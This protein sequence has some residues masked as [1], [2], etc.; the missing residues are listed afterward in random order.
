MKRTDITGQMFGRLMVTSYSHTKKNRAFWNCRCLC[1]TLRVVRGLDIRGGSTKSC[2]CL[3]R[4]KTAK[5]STTH[6]HA[7]GGKMSPT[8]YSWMSMK[9]RCLSKRHHIYKSYGGRG[10]T[11]CK[12]WLDFR[13][14]LSDMGERPKGM[15]IDRKNNNRGYSPGNCRWATAQQQARNRSDTR[16]VS[17]RG[18]VLCISDWCSLLGWSYYRLHARLSRMSKNKAMAPF[19]QFIETEK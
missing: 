9:S 14:F 19:S 8:Y 2:G 6:G 12:R 18:K 10:I 3:I 15:T 16:L 13:N 17:W 1:G 11:V 4:E 5:R 7:S